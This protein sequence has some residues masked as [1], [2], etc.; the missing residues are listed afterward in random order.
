MATFDIRQAEF[1]RILLIKPSAVGDVV[2]TLPV[3]E[4]LRRRYPQARIDWLITPENA[5]L[6]RGHPAVSNLLRF[7]R[8][9]FSKEGRKLSATASLLHLIR[10]IRA[11]KYE[12]VIDLH[13]QLRSGL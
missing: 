8:K 10:E 4:K 6:V 9:E 7:A 11:A 1:S 2:H 12:M 13:G 5:D 3:L